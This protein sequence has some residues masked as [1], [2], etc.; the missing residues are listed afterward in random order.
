MTI[1]VLLFAAVLIVLA[2]GCA[3]GKK[4]P[5]H[6]QKRGRDY[7]SVNK[8]SASFV[9]ETFRQDWSARREHS[10]AMWTVHELREK[11]ARLRKESVAFTWSSLKAGEVE[12]WKAAWTELF[13]DMLKGPEDFWASVRFGLLDSGD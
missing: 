10:K 13:P 5:Y 4:A 3:S 6:E 2:S 12:S 1:R 8:E 11:N 9:F 7:Y